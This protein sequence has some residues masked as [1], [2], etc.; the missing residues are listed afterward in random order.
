M[1]LELF[2]MHIRVDFATE[3]DY[4]A[5]LLETAEEAIVTRTRRTRAE[6]VTAEGDLPRMLQQAAMMLAAHWYNQ[7]ESASTSQMHEVPESIAALVKPY[8]RLA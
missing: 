6:L 5:H 7:P 2:K 1:D 4:L 3:D 8:R